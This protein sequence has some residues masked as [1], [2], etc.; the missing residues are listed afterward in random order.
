[1]SDTAAAGTD[2][3]FLQKVRLRTSCGK[4]VGGCPLIALGLQGNPSHSLLI[5]KKARTSG[6]E[7]VFVMQPAMRAAISGEEKGARR[8]MREARFED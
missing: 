4:E 3:M 5:R 7:Q 1:L 6:R 2:M 8:E